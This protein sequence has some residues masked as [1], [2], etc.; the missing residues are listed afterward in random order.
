MRTLLIIPLAVILLVTGLLSS[1][2]AG[3]AI[4]GYRN[5]VTATQDVERLRLLLSAQ[6]KLSI[7][8]IATNAALTVERPMPALFAAQLEQARAASSLVIDAAI[9][10]ARDNAVRGVARNKSVSEIEA[11]DTALRQARA[12]A[13]NLLAL[14][15]P[16]RSYQAI[17]DATEA[18]I[19][20]VPRFEAPV[21]EAVIDTTATDPELAGLLNVARLAINLREASGRIASL[22]IA[23]LVARVPFN[24]ADVARVR[25]L[26]GVATELD[27]MIAEGLQIAGAGDH[28]RSLAAQMHD[29]YHGQIVGLLD[30][31]MGDKGAGTSAAFLPADFTVQYLHWSGSIVAL[32]EGVLAEATFRVNEDQVARVQGL[33]WAV[34]SIGAVF[35]AVVVTLL[36]LHHYVVV[37]VSRLGSSLLRIASGERTAELASM[38]GPREIKALADAVETLRRA[39]LVADATESRDRLAA[40]QRASLLSQTL[41]IAQSVCDPAHLLTTIGE[42]L[43]THLSAAGLELADT[44][45]GLSPTVENVA[46]IVRDSTAVMRDTTDLADL[47][48]NA[49]HEVRLDG[50]LGAAQ[51]VAVRLSALQAVVD[52][53]DAAVRRFSRPVLAALNELADSNRGDPDARHGADSLLMQPFQDVQDMVATI[54]RMRDAMLR[55]H[56]ALQKVATEE[57]KAAA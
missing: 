40:Q 53:R 13:D 9:A 15:R 33:R 54:A 18:M 55:A 5:G 41:A 4:T 29:A 45:D 50:H 25:T 26:Q 24:D 23:H 34:A 19:D 52:E 51:E 49:L 32:W 20:I 12:S 39:A 27:R 3:Q 6:V 17:R 56:D 7:E 10:F 31:L 44:D 36:L 2:L 30:S 16:A 22:F 8:R 38:Q 37:P 43:V 48:M 47:A 28:A 35:V 42:R 57:T 14:D 11:I 1:M 21:L 46:Q